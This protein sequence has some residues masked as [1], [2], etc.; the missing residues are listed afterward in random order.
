MFELSAND[1]E[2]IKILTKTGDSARVVN[3]VHALNLR[4]KGFTVIEVADFLE[5]TPRTVINITNNYIEGGITKAIQDDLRIGRPV[6]I[7]DRMKSN[8][9]ALVC[10]NPPEGFDRWTLEL[11]TISTES[12][13]LVLKE[14]DLKP[15]QQKM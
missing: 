9:V 10:S 8:V 7:D 12:I 15:W 14:H 3:R 2:M 4:D 5:V 13:R 6:E 1:C 11:L